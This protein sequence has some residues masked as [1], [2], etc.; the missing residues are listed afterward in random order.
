MG[1]LGSYGNADP[2][3]VSQWVELSF[4]SSADTASWDDDRCAAFALGIGSIRIGR[5]PMGRR[6]KISSTIVNVRWQLVAV[7]SPIW[8]G[9]TNDE[10]T[11]SA[12]QSTRR[13]LLSYAHLSSAV[14]IIGPTSLPISLP[15]PS[16]L[17]PLAIYLSL[18]PSCT[19]VGCAPAWCRRWSIGYCTPRWAL[20]RTHRYSKKM[21]K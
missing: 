18:S 9:V 4:S 2:L 15:A 17:P 10:M 14:A 13:P 20:R 16:G 6:I 19:K 11:L 3:D 12:P 1:Y 21:P 5:G 8:R 7:S